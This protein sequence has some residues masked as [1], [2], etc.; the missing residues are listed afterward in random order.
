MQNIS[1]YFNPQPPEGGFYSRNLHFSVLEK[2]P[3]RGFRGLKH[4]RLHNIIIKKVF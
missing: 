4:L 2:V 1:S 3:F